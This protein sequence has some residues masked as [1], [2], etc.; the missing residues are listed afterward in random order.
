MMFDDA[1][2]MSQLN[3]Y[4]MHTYLELTAGM[5]FPKKKLGQK[6][7]KTLRVRFLKQVFQLCL[8]LVCLCV[9][10]LGWI[11]PLKASTCALLQSSLSPAASSLSFTLHFWAWSDD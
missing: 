10:F 1:F 2:P 5:L 3:R 4:F 6:K 7:K 9:V 11:V 8:T